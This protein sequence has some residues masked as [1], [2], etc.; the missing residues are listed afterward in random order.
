VTVRIYDL[1]PGY[2][3]VG[4]SLHAWEKTW[5]QRRLRRPPGRILVGACGTG[6]EA[7]AL[8]EEGFRVDAFD[9]A[10]EFVAESRRRLAG[11]ARVAQF[12]YEIL[13]A[14]VLD[15]A[16]KLDQ[17]FHRERYD[18]VLLGCGSLTHVLDPREQ[19][20]LL[21]ALD[22]LCPAGPILASFFQADETAT[23][24]PKADRAMRFGLALGR[25]IASLRG[26]R[27]EEAP[28][29]SFR[30][31]SGFAHTFSRQEIEALGGG[32][33]RQVVWDRDDTQAGHVTFLPP[34]ART[35]G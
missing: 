18:A 21:R 4:N 9:P 29:Q 35:D 12:S 17:E 13:S 25:G 11:R 8:V 32:V 23:Q 16:A 20:R 2:K 15:G 31:R 30:Q 19:G 5:F 28:R 26:I 34:G 3:H 14:A 7:V 6:R 27:C 1:Y 24:A 10:P 33:N 22:V